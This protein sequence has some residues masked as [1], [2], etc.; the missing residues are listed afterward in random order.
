MKQAV[1]ASVIRQIR[2]SQLSYHIL[3]GKEK[4]STEFRDVIVLLIDIFMES[5]EAFFRKWAQKTCQNELKGKS[6]FSILNAFVGINL[7]RSRLE[8]T[9]FWKSILGKNI[10]AQTGWLVNRT[11]VWQNKTKHFKV[12]KWIE[13]WRKNQ[14]HMAYTGVRAT[15]IWQRLW[16]K[17]P[18]INSQLIPGYCC[19]ER[20][21]RRCFC[22]LIY[23]FHW[24]YWYEKAV[25]SVWLFFSCI[26]FFGRS[27]KYS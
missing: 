25:T 24:D 14:E 19:D 8:I 4:G 5:W 23:S 17:S 15:F 13:F 18:E 22:L 11:G 9:L 6:S 7:L 12:R 10:L 16:S 21:C 2:K 3:H 20:K 26:L 27:N 1:S